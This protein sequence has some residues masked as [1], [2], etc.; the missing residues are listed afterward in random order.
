MFHTTELKILHLYKQL[1]NKSIS[2]IFISK[3]D[4]FFYCDNDNLMEFCIFV[5][6]TQVYEQKVEETQI[7]DSTVERAHTF[8]FV[9]IPFRWISA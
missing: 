7:K 3:N 4:S 8:S 1:K 9:L 5:K 6:S 2:N